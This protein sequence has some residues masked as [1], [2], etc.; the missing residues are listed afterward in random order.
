[1][2]DPLKELASKKGVVVKPADI[3]KVNATIEYLSKKA[4]G[5]PVT[6]AEVVNKHV[7]GDRLPSS[8]KQMGS[9]WIDAMQKRYP[10][11]FRSILDPD[12]V[13]VQGVMQ[14][15]NDIAMN[16]EN[17][18]LAIAAGKAVMDVVVKVEKLVH[19]DARAGVNQMFEGKTADDIV[20]DLKRRT[21]TIDV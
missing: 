20:A 21:Q 19:E 7:P 5:Q 9:Q 4:S 18:G 1:M 17:E 10:I 12:V 16:T 13:N 11:I 2:N 3:P 8:A 14:R 15:M 6:M